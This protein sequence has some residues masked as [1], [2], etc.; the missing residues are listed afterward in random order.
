MKDKAQVSGDQSDTNTPDKNELF[1]KTLV[2]I[3]SIFVLKA[4]LRYASL[5]QCEF[6]R[7]LKWNIVIP[8]DQLACESC[9][10]DTN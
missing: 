10:L 9:S 3:H 5:F 4:S 2:L 1:I 6:L 8:I 7:A